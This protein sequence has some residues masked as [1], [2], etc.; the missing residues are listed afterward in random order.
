MAH[1]EFKVLPAP[2]R[3]K[4]MKGL[5]RGQNRFCATVT[6]FLNENG[7]DGWEFI[8]FE[9]MPLESRR[10]LFF[11]YVGECPCMIFRREVEPMV[12]DGTSNRDREA[13]A[14]VHETEQGQAEISVPRPQR[15]A[16]AHVV[17]MVRTGERVLDPDGKL[18]PAPPQPEP[19]EELEAE[20]LTQSGDTAGVAPA[21]GARPVRPVAA[22]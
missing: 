8:G 10:F 6:E 16:R 11:Q 2:R 20:A 12:L 18:V 15:V 19:M 4:R 13:E 5:M 3:S 1:F 7:L 17:D 21:R 14:A 9:M 22:G